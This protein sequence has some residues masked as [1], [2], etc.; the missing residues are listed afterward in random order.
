MYAIL[1]TIRVLP[2]H[3]EE[4]LVHVRR[5]AARSLTEPGCVRFDVLQDRDDPLTVCLYEVFRE[6][7]DLETH[8]THGYYRQWMEMSRPWRDVAAGSRRV[9]TNIHPPDEAFGG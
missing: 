9:L 3:L 8:R 1:G 7:A 5:H 2:A 4:F 6:E